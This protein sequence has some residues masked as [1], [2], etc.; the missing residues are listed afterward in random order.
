LGENPFYLHILTAA[1]IFM[2]AHRQITW[3]GMCIATSYSCR[4]VATAL[5]A[6]WD[7]EGGNE[8]VVPIRLREEMKKHA[9]KQIEVY[10]N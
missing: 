8:V 10:N 9:M 5:V 6:Y 7:S 1:M 3:M 2:K 4:H